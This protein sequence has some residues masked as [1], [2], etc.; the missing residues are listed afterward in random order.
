MSEYYYFYSRPVNLMKQM[1][2]FCLLVMLFLSLTL[3]DVSDSF[4]DNKKVIFKRRERRTVNNGRL[5]A[6]NQNNTRPVDVRLNDIL[7]Q[8]NHQELLQYTPR[9]P[10]PENVNCHVEVPV[11]QRVGGRCVQLGNQMGCQAGIYLAFSSE[12]DRRGRRIIPR[13]QVPVR[14]N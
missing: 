9:A 4:P 5:I 10:S 8:L 3:F 11:T 7:N 6:Q 12:C 14:R 2:Y 13:Q 1:V